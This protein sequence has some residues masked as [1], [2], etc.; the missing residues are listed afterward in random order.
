MF[1]LVW[2]AGALTGNQ[3]VQVRSIEPRSSK[4]T[5]GMVTKRILPVMNWSI[6]LISAIDLI[7]VFV[8]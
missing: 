7:V 3:N 2:T 8:S 1:M 6:K 5:T 4:M